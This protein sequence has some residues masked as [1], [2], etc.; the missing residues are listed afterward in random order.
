MVGALV[1]VSTVDVVHTKVVV[2]AAVVAV[3]AMAQV[4]GLCCCC[5]C[6]F[7]CYLYDI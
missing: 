3:A 2:V 6:S 5:Y 7:T 4:V 1:F